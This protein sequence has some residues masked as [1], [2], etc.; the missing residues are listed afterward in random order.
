MRGE[1]HGQRQHNSGEDEPLDIDRWARLAGVPCCLCFHFA[2]NERRTST[3][4]AVCG[5]LLTALELIAL[6]CGIAAR[7]TA[8]GKAGIVIAGI[9]LLLP[10]TVLVLLFMPSGRLPGA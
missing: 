1:S 6:G 7:S 4:L 2:E 10:I 3:A 8:T 9:V 5:I